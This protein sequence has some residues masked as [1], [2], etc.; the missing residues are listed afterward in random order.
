MS[1]PRKILVIAAALA[2]ASPAVV[3]QSIKPMSPTEI[4]RLG[5]AAPLPV[6]P[7][8]A[9]QPAASGY[10][11]DATGLAVPSRAA[12][13][14]AAPVA[15]ALP[16]P[17]VLQQPQMAV[18]TIPAGTR[19]SEGLELFVS[20]RGW[21]LRWLIEEDYMLDAD[22]PIPGTNVIDAVTWVVQTYQRQGGMRGVVPMFARGNRVVAI[23]NMDVRDNE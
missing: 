13:P 1:Q 9:V 8:A 11:P 12:A 3:A 23:Q 5:T 20:S 15:G 16:P 7:P 6:P 22:L 19:L 14:V 2:I 10:Q 18:T 4:S 21:S 17:P